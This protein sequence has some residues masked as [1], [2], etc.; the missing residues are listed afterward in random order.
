MR[1]LFCNV[2]NDLQFHRFY[3]LFFYLTRILLTI[4][5]VIHIFVVWMMCLEYYLAT[6]SQTNNNEVNFDHLK[7]NNLSI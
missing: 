1:S 7:K 5:I 3:F 4:C 6:K 2:Y